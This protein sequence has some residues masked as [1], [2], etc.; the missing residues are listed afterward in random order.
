M[1]KEELV[2]LIIEQYCYVKVDKF[3]SYKEYKKYLKIN[4]TFCSTLNKEQDNLYLQLEEA[5]MNYIIKKENEI[6]GFVLD[7]LSAFKT[8]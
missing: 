7:F 4:E 8:Y 3:D 5:Y 2:K 6:I 1:S